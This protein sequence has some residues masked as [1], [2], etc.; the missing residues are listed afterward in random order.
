MELNHRFQGY[1]SLDL[2]KLM[3]IYQ[4]SL[5]D[6]EILVWA[7]NVTCVWK[8]GFFQTCVLSDLIPRIGQTVAHDVIGMTYY[9]LTNDSSPP[10]VL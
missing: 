9:K 7:C 6:Y 2:D 8:K 1:I 5:K 10:L 4:F 3:K